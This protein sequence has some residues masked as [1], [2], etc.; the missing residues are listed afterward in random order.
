M[1]D[2]RMHLAS[3]Q[4]KVGTMGAIQERYTA[5]IET[6][7]RTASASRSRETVEVEDGAEAYAHPHERGIATRL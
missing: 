4:I 5:A 7:I 6:A 2:R 3:L 1:G